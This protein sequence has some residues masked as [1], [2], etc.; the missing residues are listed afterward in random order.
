MLFAWYLTIAK[1]DAIM[2][3]KSKQNKKRQLANVH[4][5]KCCWCD[6]PLTKKEQTLEHI[7]PRSRKG[8]NSIDNL[9]LACFSCNNSRGNRPYPSGF[10]QQ[11]ICPKKLAFLALIKSLFSQPSKK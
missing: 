4:G 11:P 7:K 10:P 2:T 9:R 5:S 8:S 1:R 3:P 6:K